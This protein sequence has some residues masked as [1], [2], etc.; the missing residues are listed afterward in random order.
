MQAPVA[1]TR[2]RTTKPWR[3]S[4]LASSRNLAPVPV[5]AP[6]LDSFFS[7]CILVLC[8][9]HNTEAGTLAPGDGLGVLLYGDE[10]ALGR[11]LA[12]KAQSLCYLAVEGSPMAFPQVLDND[13]NMKS[14]IC[15]KCLPGSMMDETNRYAL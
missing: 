1:M 7:H 3:T 13:T 5:A 4:S 12:V 11:P 9:V 2:K 8:G 14:V 15:S 6:R 10:R